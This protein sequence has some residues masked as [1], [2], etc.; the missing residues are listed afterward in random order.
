MS[1]LVFIM[2]RKK[3]TIKKKAK[4]RLAGS[5]VAAGFPS[6]ANEY[7]DR[8]LDLNEYLVTQP[9]AT[10]FV[11]V[12]GDSMQGAGIF[13]GDLL[14]VDRSAPP[15]D[16]KIVIAFIDGEFTVKRLEKK[17]KKLRL[18]PENPRFS[19]IEITGE[20]EMVVWGVVTGVVR[21]V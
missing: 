20:M 2:K 5:A 1:A 3:K 4:P 17:G 11:R 12:E 15:L 16:G 8:P 18:L 7:L 6:P 19:P 13:S 21:K 9:V 10:F 14:V